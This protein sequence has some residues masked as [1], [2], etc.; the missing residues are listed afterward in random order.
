MPSV[1]LARRGSLAAGLLRAAATL[2][3]PLLPEDYLSV[4]NPLWSSRDRRGRVERVI[5]ETADAATLVIRPGPGWP[6]HRAG[7]WVAIGARIRGVWHSRTYSLTSPAAGGDA[8]LL[9]VTVRAIPGGQVSNHLVH[10]TRP[11]ALL[12]LGVP[13]GEFVLPDPPPARIL[14]L[15]AGSGITPVM[16]MLRTMAAGFAGSDVW[17]LHCER[18]AQDVIFGAELR[19]LSHRLP[20]YRLYERHTARDGR[21]TLTQLQR[22][23]PDWRERTTWAC[24][25]PGLL[26]DIEAHWDHAD[27]PAKLHIERF[28]APR[29]AT[30]GAEGGAVTFTTSGRTVTAP[31]DTPLLAVGEQAG[32]AMPHGCRMGICLSCLAPLRSG[33]VRDLR[34]GRVHGEAGDLIQTCVSATAG[35]CDIDL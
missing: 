2:T 21:F 13:Q 19:A 17:H 22:L 30:P 10:R 7:Q 18:R 1:A 27:A 34:T 12:R 15:T 29:V 28:Q 5:R 16:G 11:G 20:N 4:I 14:F 9:R 8:G 31:A 23:C 6:G 24:G 33:Q 3:T 32:V 26:A 35:G 25:P